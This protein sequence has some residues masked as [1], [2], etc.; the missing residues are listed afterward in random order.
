MTDED[1]LAAMGIKSA[2]TGGARLHGA[3]PLTLALRIDDLRSDYCEHLER[4]ISQQALE[5]DLLRKLPGI[6]SNTGG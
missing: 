5:I 3:D 2:S 4:R 1:F 6:P